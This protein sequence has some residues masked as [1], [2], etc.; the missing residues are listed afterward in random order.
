MK[1]RQ[2]ERKKSVIGDNQSSEA[3]NA[4]KMK[5]AKCKSSQNNANRDSSL[6]IRLRDPEVLRYGPE[7]LRYASL[8]GISSVSLRLSPF[9][10]RN[11]AGTAQVYRGVLL[12]Y[13][14]LWLSYIFHFSQG[15]WQGAIA[16]GRSRDPGRF[17]SSFGDLPSLHTVHPVLQWLCQVK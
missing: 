2:N 7:V 11:P 5:N 3:G 10:S 1:K 14:A 12:L 16:V 17:S 6:G 9:L 15:A 13:T 4:M 8:E